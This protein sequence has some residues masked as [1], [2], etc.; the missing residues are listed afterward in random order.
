ML[1]ATISNALEEQDLRSR[2][3]TDSAVDGV[4]GNSG[5]SDDDFDAEL[6]K[7]R[8]IGEYTGLWFEDMGKPGEAKKRMFEKCEDDFT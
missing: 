4:G 5:S 7:Y 3:I 8:W 6:L 1:R 2:G